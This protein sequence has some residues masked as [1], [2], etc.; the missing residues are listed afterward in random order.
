MKEEKDFDFYARKIQAIYRGRK[1]RICLEGLK[2]VK[3]PP[4]PAL[5]P[6]LA[7]VISSEYLCKKI[8]PIYS[9]GALIDLFI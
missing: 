7:Q 3:A 1:D 5:I 8:C 2:R 9:S 4:Q 6:I